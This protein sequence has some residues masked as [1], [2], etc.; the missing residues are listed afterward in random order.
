LKE[1]CQDREELAFLPGKA[2]YQSSAQPRDFGLNPMSVEIKIGVD[3]GAVTVAVAVL[4]GNRLISK[5]YR[6]HHGD[7]ASTLTGVL[8]EL[9]GTR[10]L[11]GFTGRGGKLFGGNRKVNEVVATV[12]GVKWA[13]RRIPRS[14][15]LIGGENI[16]LIQLNDDGTYRHHKINTDCASGTGVFLDQQA[17]RLGLETKDLAALAARFK[18]TPPSIAT[19]CAVFAKTDLIHSQQ[20]GHS[21]AGIAAGL[22]DGVAQCL[23]DTL[24]KDYGSLGEV[25][26]AGGVALNKRVVS[27]LEGIFRQA[28]EVLPNAEVIPAIGAALEAKEPASLIDFRPP[29]ALRAAEGTILNPPLLLSRSVIPDF[30]AD[31]TWRED[32]IEVAVYE[33]LIRGRTYDSYLGLDIGSTSTKLVVACRDSVI[34]G[35][36][37][38]TNSAPIRAVQKLFRLLALLENKQG[39]CFRWLGVGTTGSGRKLIGKLLRADFIIN[40]ITAH[41]RAAVLL[42]P[43]VDTVIEIGGQDSKFI[44]VRNGAV[45]QA[46]MNYIC[47]AGTGSFIEEQAKRLDVS[48]DDYSRLAMGRRG[49]VISDRCTVYMERDLS[50]L[51]SAGWPKEDLLASVL[52]SVRDNYLMR[53]VGQAKIGQRVCFQGATA[54]NTALVAAFEVGLQKPIRVSR[55]CH[56]AGAL[57]VCLLLKEK[58]IARTNFI[59]LG[60]SSWTY[61]QR[62]EECSL[63]R[64]RCRITVVQAGEERTAWGFM[65]GREYEDKAYKEKTL[66]F[67][68]IADIYAR[69]F[70]APRPIGFPAVTRNKRIGIPRALPLVEYL[71]LWQDFFSCLGFGTLVSPQDKDILKRG[72]R[73]AEAEF[74]SPILHAHGHADWLEKE[75]ADFIFFPIMLHGPKRDRHEKRGYFCYYTAHTPVLLRNSP[76][77]RDGHRLLSPLLDLRLEPDQISDSLF[78]AIG[79]PLRLSKNDIRRAFGKSWYRFLSGRKNLASHGAKVL[80][81]LEGRD[82]LAV[83]LLGRPYNL[84]DRSL[85]QGIP[86]LIQQHGY[87][88]LLPDMLDL[89]PV[90]P[91]HTESYLEKIHW[92]YG[93]RILQTAEWVIRHRHLFPVFLT[94]FRCSPDAFIISYF[95]E[96][97]ENQGKPYLILQLDELSSEVGY[98]TRIEAALESF[99]NWR[100][101]Q[102]RPSRPFV[103]I[104]LRKDKTWILPHLDDAT[105]PLVQAI[106]GRSGFES[107]V[108]LE[109]PESIVQGMKLVG[110]GE[111][112]PVGAI[113]G[114]IVGTVD[115]YGL[116][117]GRTAAM[118]PSSIVSCNFPQIPLAVQTGL[119]KAGLGDVRIFT[120]GTAGMSFS[121]SFN[122]ALGH[123][124]IVGG[125]VHQMTAKVRPYEAQPGETELVKA[126]ALN[127]L[128]RAIIEKRSL[129]ATFRETVKDFEAIP[130]LRTDGPRPVL[131]VFGDLYVVCNSI[132]NQRVEKAIEASGGE[133]LPT[134]FVE[135]SHFS[136]LNRYERSLKHKHYR[137]AAEAKALLTY[138]RHYDRRYREAARPVLKEVHP[139]MDGAMLMKL[140]EIGI[141]PELDGETSLNILKSIYYLQYLKPD[142]FV[143]V[144]PLYC[145]PGAV[146]SALLSWVEKEYGV[147]VI[148]LFYD[149]LH[150]PN[151]NLEP[152]IY[153]LRQKKAESWSRDRGRGKW[154]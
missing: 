122:L 143:H 41:S 28:V 47:A 100:T 138:L 23:A 1:P 66:P 125:L 27:A 140:R 135:M 80:S 67:E 49:P 11:V 63:C 92:H 109:T 31:R 106:L 6:F 120:T 131:A 18:E 130:V 105:T 133:A 33:R 57:G 12:E 60:F 134:S 95:K 111:C 16:L 112:V 124:T 101:S 99:R 96:L 108:S 89:G 128:C 65:C 54:R 42:D 148:N 10:A 71:P 26:I 79:R 5:S 46:I 51:L 151:E 74:C 115:K 40:E 21:V 17:G 4:R 13:A 2:E 104:P 15:L 7:V 29:V 73:R 25:C 121:P 117:P 137:N 50:E 76:L 153:Y 30:S 72:K 107:V 68:P 147:P 81:E 61:E 22:C 45:V 150:S 85:S 48:L 14:I 132:F 62:T 88:V 55:Y 20:E 43:E 52:H 59:G 139:I 116:A 94:N 86:D 126:S 87:R 32:D 103:F 39:V 113:L 127:K 75:G 35:L 144:N 98:E 77:S 37:T 152:Y 90:E 58:G 118:I 145:C 82:D 83:V 110:G 114:G 34:L 149:G 129:L 70:S 69:A 97:M 38:Y 44:G 8:N 93:L 3:I 53:V 102:P 142:G 141:P 123:A 56:L 78:Q 146:S 84:L 119:R 19:R 154:T 91:A 9:S 36:Y 64:N 136:Y 24:I